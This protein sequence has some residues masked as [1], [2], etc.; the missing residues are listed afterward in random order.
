MYNHISTN[1]FNNLIDALYPI[2]VGVLESQDW[3][4]SD[5]REELITVLR[6]N[7]GAHLDSRLTADGF[8]SLLPK[9]KERLDND[10]I[11]IFSLGICH[12]YIF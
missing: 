10:V 8:L 1:F 5:L 11:A 3:D 12:Q 7:Y 9:I 4:V 6:S 2:R